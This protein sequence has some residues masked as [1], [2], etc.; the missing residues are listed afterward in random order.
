MT[1]QGPYP[2]NPSTSPNLDPLWGRVPTPA[3]W[4]DAIQ[5]LPRA[6]D[7]Q[8]RINP[9]ADLSPSLD[10]S[11]PAAW[12]AYLLPP[13]QPGWPPISDGGAD[14]AGASNIAAG[15]Q[16]P[17]NL[18]TPSGATAP[19]PGGTDSQTQS[20]GGAPAALPNG[21]VTYPLTWANGVGSYQWDAPQVAIGT[22]SSVTPTGQWG[23]KGSIST[24]NPDGVASI[25]APDPKAG[26]LI[27]TFFDA[28][29]RQS[30]GTF[31]VVPGRTAYLNDGQ[32]TV[33][34]GLPQATPAASP[35]SSQSSD[36]IDSLDDLRLAQARFSRVT[37]DMDPLGA[38]YRGL[39]NFMHRIQLPRVGDYVSMAPGADPNVAEIQADMLQAY[40]PEA[41]GTRPGTANDI[42][43][44]VSALLAPI[45][46]EGEA[47]AGP[48]LEGLEALLG[49]TRSLSFEYRT[50]A[51][52]L[53]PAQAEISGVPRFNPNI[54]AH[55]VGA[56]AEER[57]ANVVQSLPD[58]QV[59]RWGDPIG[60][61]GSDVI[62]VNGRTG[63]VT[64]WDAKYRGTDVRITHS[65]T[66]RM[67]SAP[68]QNALQQATDAIKQDKILPEGVR[69]R[70]LDN[71]T[72][73]NFNTRT[74]GYGRALNSI[75]G[76]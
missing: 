58:E 2:P 30:L 39:D 32:T 70:A 4:A 43:T 69:Q 14:A 75:M 17:P 62:S 24:T 51:L 21:A 53:P 26:Q 67:D 3:D 68:R 31:P 73:K 15:S 20:I 72:V 47:E 13:G 35:D 16:L 22:D 65:N 12:S 55:A 33:S 49:R 37:H 71:L 59:V 44:P 18:V 34:Y 41:R 25:D 27:R 61:H 56:D 28:K 5:A 46:G 9:P 48:T 57:L 38:A 74:V 45:G 40:V 36:L 66:F 54:Y 76:N 23:G 42:I 64:L 50:P 7:F 11:N 10:W 19:A 63:E 60:T 1:S 6:D 52:G 8:P 29:T